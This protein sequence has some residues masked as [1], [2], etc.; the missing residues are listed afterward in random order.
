MSIGFDADPLAL[1]TSLTGITALTFIVIQQ[2]A[3]PHL[4]LKHRVSDDTPADDP[5][6]ARYKVEMNIW[7]FTIAL[8]W[9]EAAAFVF[10]TPDATIAES[11][12]VGLATA[13]LAAFLAVG[14]H[15]VGTN[16]R[17]LRA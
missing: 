9:A 8:A 14:T 4:R 5:A 15:E 13:V 17:A 1:L 2:L 12:L 3:K 10:R 6:R 7:A 11:A 16:V